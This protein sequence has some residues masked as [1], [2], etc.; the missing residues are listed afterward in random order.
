MMFN[1]FMMFGELFLLNVFAGGSLW[2]RLDRHDD[3]TR[4]QHEDECIGVKVDAGRNKNGITQPSMRNCAWW[5]KLSDDIEI[6]PLTELA[7][8]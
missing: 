4:A 3:V 2:Q 6:E 8:D 1:I 7:V 5:Q